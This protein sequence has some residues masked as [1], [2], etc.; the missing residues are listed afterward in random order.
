MSKLENENYKDVLKS[1][2]TE[3]LGNRGYQSRLAAAAGCSR[4]FLS[5]VLAQHL[6]IHLTRD[7]AAG[8]CAFWNFNELQFEIFLLQ[9]DFAKAKSTALKEHAAAKIKKLKK[10]QIKLPKEIAKENISEMQSQAIYYSTWLMA[11][12]H[13]A[14][15]IPEFQDPKQLG[16]RL[17]LNENQIEKILIKLQEIGLA[18]KSDAHWAPTK[19][20]IN[21]NENSDFS[22]SNHIHWR[23]RAISKIYS[24]KPD[25]IHF[26]SVF[27]FNRKDV[28]ALNELIK[29]MILD[30]R[31]L[32]IQ[33]KEEELYCL[34]IDFF[35]I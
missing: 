14:I 21:L 34:N 22:T 13:M 16:Q 17:G 35:E 5:Q 8:M 33:S 11:A 9:L 20:D 3:N 28:R 29:K 12:V 26:S 30:S 15:T 1:K 6:D 32:I 23:N 4:S 27:S 2:I 25:S 18:K 7:H 19:K 24:R 31:D 10:E